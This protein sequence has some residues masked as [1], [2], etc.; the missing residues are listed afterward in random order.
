TE[1]IFNEQSIKLSLC[2]IELNNL[3]EKLK[4]TI[5]EDLIDGDLKKPAPV[6]AATTTTMTATHTSTTTTS[7]TAMQTST[8]TT[9]SP[10][11]FYVPPGSPIHQPSQSTLAVAPDKKFEI[12]LRTKLKK[13]M[14]DY[15]GINF[16]QDQ[17]GGWMTDPGKNATEIGLMRTDFLGFVRDN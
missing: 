3:A 11:K 6:T 9:S 13:L 17:E 5:K 12:S 7:M 1:D 2:L 15:P 8:T 14:Q 4:F 16:L 10:T